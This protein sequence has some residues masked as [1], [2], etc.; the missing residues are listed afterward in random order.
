MASD[1]NAGTGGRFNQPAAGDTGMTKSGRIFMENSLI[2]S[3]G[4]PQKIGIVRT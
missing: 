3:L 1:G 2:F 4:E